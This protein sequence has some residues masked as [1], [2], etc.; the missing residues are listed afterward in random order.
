VSR[1]E[2]A[3]AARQLSA[4][5]PDFSSAIAHLLEHTS[6]AERIELITTLERDA[7]AACDHH[8]RVARDWAR[9]ADELARAINDAR[10]GATTALTFAQI[11]NRLGDYRDAR[12]ASERAQASFDQ[13]D[14]R[15]RALLESAWASIG[16]GDLQIA[17]AELERA[18]ALSAAP[19][20]HT[21]AAWIHARIL[22][23]QAQY[24]EAKT[25]FERARANASPR[26]ATRCALEFAY[27]RVLNE[28]TDVLPVI[29]ALRET[30]QRAQCPLDVAVCDRI[31]AIALTY[32]Q[33]YRDAMEIIAPARRAF[34]D[35]DAMHHVAECDLLI[36]ML[37]DRMHQYAHA[38]APLRACREYCR[39]N[40]ARSLA[41]ACA[42]NLGN[43]HYALNQYS[44]A[45]ACYQ[46][47]AALTAGD[48]RATREARVLINIGMVYIK[49]AR[50]ADAL[51]AHQRALDIA[52]RHDLEVLAVGSHQT[53]AMCYRELGRYDEALHHLNQ[54]RA[55]CLKRDLCD[56]LIFCDITLAELHRTRG[57]PA[58]ARA[59]LERAR[60]IALER[61]LDSYAAMCERALAHTLADDQALAHLASARARFNA[62][63]QTI[64]VALCD[65][66]E[67]ELHLQWHALDA[68]KECFIRARA[69]LTPGFPD[70]AWRAEAGLARCAHARGDCVTALAHYRAATRDIADL[71]AALIAEQF[72]DAFFA[73]RQ[74]VYADALALAVELDD[75]PAAFDIIEASKARAFLALLDTRGWQARRD[76]ADGNIGGLIARERELRN[77]LQTLRQR[78]TAQTNS[79][80]RDDSATARAELNARAAQYE[81]V[82][83]QL[84][85]ATRGLA[86]A[87][88]PAPFALAEFRAAMCATFG[89]DWRALDYAWT[90][91]QI[92][93][94]EIAPDTTRLTHKT[95]SAFARKLL[96]QCVAVERDLRE[97]V[98]RGTVRGARVP[99]NDKPLREMY[100]LL[101]PSDLR[102]STLIIAPHRA[103]HNL[104]FHALRDDAG[105]LIEKH[106][107]VYAPSLQ[108]LQSL[109]RDPR[110]E[111]R[112]DALVCGLANFGAELP[113]LE[114]AE[115]E[116]AAL[117][118]MLRGKFL[119]G[120]DATRQMLFDLNA[121]GELAQFDLLHFA[122]HALLDRAA[123]HQSRIALFDA[124][125]TTF[126][127]LELALNARV[128]TLSA[129]QTAL[130]ARGAGDE[131]IGL[132]RAF[133]YAGARAL[134]ATLWHVEDASTRDLVARVYQHYAR[135]ENL[136]AALRRAQIEMLRAGQS[137]YQWASLIM[138]GKP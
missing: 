26:D 110:A 76:D 28:E 89:D 136:A 126:D 5:A 64:D 134:L 135:G 127:I 78:V 130:G 65:L 12:A 87:P 68:A 32:A 80:A 72:S 104:P 56:G 58:P 59:C 44:A 133:F 3:I 137:P 129:C 9:V 36:G 125:L 86:G 60:A 115:T 69:A 27:A 131:L 81:T 107:L 122:T 21:R 57:D 51:A 43:A 61:G 63:A 119:W 66:I 55:T 88:M 102:A 132:A 10:L 67:G 93:I 15:A 105:Y 82:V 95:L 62:H 20:I 84:R 39:A 25:W 123:P 83:A 70:H 46:D 112:G 109:L 54:A 90:E 29:A 48:G 22:R 108:V 53:L 16:I 111:P 38:L 18:R 1:A 113:A 7:R 103:L 19:D 37:H 42:I 106:A 121:T 138:M 120:A 92:I 99:F 74:A 34:A 52:T 30:F 11:A 2:R 23:N 128:V 96:E 45:L 124:P 116:V 14:D 100:R 8:P 31:T 114:F 47:A 117:R 118:A 41:S 85:L 94:L 71:R 77:D 6:L 49:Q 50:F 35:L 17:R 33:R 4:H 73:Q 91:N 13:H 40:G 79:H 24:P 97:R 75:A 101:I 98:Y